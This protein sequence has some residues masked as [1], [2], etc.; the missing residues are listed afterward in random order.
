MPD[1]MVAG[2]SAFELE[3]CRPANRASV[4][5]FTALSG[6]LRDGFEQGFEV[7]HCSE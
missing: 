6:N 3:D 2:V 5:R 1:K 7:N 4:W